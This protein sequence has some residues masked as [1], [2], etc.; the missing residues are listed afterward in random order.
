MMIERMFTIL[1]L[2][3]I[4]IYSKSVYQTHDEILQEINDLYLQGKQKEATLAF[5]TLFNN[6][7][8]NK[9]IVYEYYQF[10]LKIGDFQKIINNKITF[11]LDNETISKL[12]HDQNILRFGNIKEKANLFVKYPG[13]FEVLY[14]NALYNFEHNDK[15]KFISFL[16]RLK[17]INSQHK[18]VLI[19]EARMLMEDNKYTEG[20]HLFGMAGNIE[21]KNKILSL[22]HELNQID[23]YRNNKTKLSNLLQLHTII[24]KYI[25]LDQYKP[26]VY[27]GMEKLILEK[28][29]DIY[30]A[31][32]L[33]GGST[34][35]KRLINMSTDKKNKINNVIKHI[36]NLLLENDITT[37]ETLYS[38]FKNDMY[39]NTASFLQQ[40]IN[41]LRQKIIKKEQEKRQWEEQRHYEQQ[42]QNNI[43]K[44]NNAGKDFLGYYK[45]LGITNKSSEKD[46]KKGWK[47]AAKKAQLEIK[48]NEAKTGKKDET[49]LIKVN[50]AWE[51][52]GCK[53][54]KELYDAG[55][56]PTN[57]QQ[58]ANYNYQQQFNFD[59]GFDDIN[60]ILAQFFGGGDGFGSYNNGRRIVRRFVFQ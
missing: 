46:I 6:N 9:R 53:E 13:C 60:E 25:I 47:K 2:L 8:E 5:E 39:A 33:K 31:S 36:Q 34:Y 32:G 45:L 51:V 4:T 17:K 29:V 44:T 43:K 49:P 54:K 59:G 56:D 35:S 52:L 42:R 22:N 21:Y 55:I 41:Q 3:I 7:I 14:Y 30:L 48:Q 23:N 11:D 1:Y 28:I 50:K 20:A 15:T 12:E 18:N 57:S 58:R 19:L 27:L 38:Q 10:L 37:A 40:K 24:K 16:D 26:S